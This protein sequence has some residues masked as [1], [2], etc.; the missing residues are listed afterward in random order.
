MQQEGAAPGAEELKLRGTLKRAPPR[1]CPSQYVQVKNL[2][3]ACPPVPRG[4]HGIRKV[5]ARPAATVS[6]QVPRGVTAEFC[7]PNHIRSL[8]LFGSVLTNRSGPESDIDIL[9]ELEAD[10]RPTLLT[11]ARLER[12]LSVALGR[13]VD[14]RMSGDLSRYFRERVIAAAVPQY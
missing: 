5:G 13:R 11:L 4:E 8:S 1:G 14:L 10:A 3:E 12:E 6:I 2:P 9:V 7:R